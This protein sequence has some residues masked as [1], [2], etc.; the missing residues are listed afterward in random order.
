MYQFNE[1]I[2][3]H[4]SNSDPVMM[5][6]IKHVP[7]NSR[8]SSF[9]TSLEGLIDIVISQQLALSVASKLNEAFLN[10]F[11]PIRKAHLLTFTAEDFKSIGLSRAKSETIERIV[12]SSIDFE[13]LKD[14]SNEIIFNTLT[15]LKGLGPWSAEMFIMFIKEDQNFF[16]FNDGGIKN[17]LKTFYNGVNHQ[18]LAEKFDPYKSYACLVLWEAL[19]LKKNLLKKMEE[20]N[21]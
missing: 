10:T 2:I 9:K 15:S 6:L 21:D 13:A 5:T 3:H 18:A 16:S 1:T 4:L 17:A 8:I 14:A 12:H 11:G 7:L 19:A 20:D